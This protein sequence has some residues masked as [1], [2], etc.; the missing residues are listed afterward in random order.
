MPWL[1]ALYHVHYARWL[2]VHI[3]DMKTLHTSNPD[4]YQAFNNSG[5]FVVA[6][7]K[8]PFSSMG[9]DQRHEQHNKDLKGDGGILGL[10]EHEEKLR[11]WMVCGPE[12][13]RAVDEFELSS[14]LRR[15][16]T[17]E[18]RHHEQTPGFQKRFFN[19]VNTTTEEFNKLGN[20][21]SDSYGEDLVQISTRDVMDESVVKSVCSIEESGKRL[22]ETFLGERI[23]SRIK[24]IDDPIRKNK[25]ALFSTPY[26]R[27][28]PSMSETEKKGLKNDIRIFS[29]LYI[30]T[31]TRDGDL[32]TFFSHENSAVPP[33]LACNGKIRS[34]VKSDLLGCLKYPPTVELNINQP[35]LSE[36]ENESSIT[37][38]NRLDGKILE[39]SVLVNMLKPPKGSTFGEYARTL[40]LPKVAKELQSVSRIDIVFDCYKKNSLKETARQRRGTGIRRKV[41]EL[42]QTP[43]NW[44][45]FLRID[46]NKTELFSFL[47]EQMTSNP[48]LNKLVIAAFEDVVL[49][50]NQADVRNLSPC[51]H[52]EADTC[53]FLHALDMSNNGLQNVMIKLWILMWLYWQCLCMQS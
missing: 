20:P 10:T 5:C 14:V 13:A 37:A 53:V 9:L 1:F 51:N 38:P 47:S 28:H 25:F 43:S 48:E 41:E 36:T 24:D 26:Q 30:A 50:S 7:T 44:H 39:G 42:S 22:Y 29:Q 23:N 18:Y 19:H 16:E 27:K 15:E 52:E 2:S 35:G 34:G 3:H 40:F 33:A 17:T 8:N 11:R 32:D 45:S 6:R 12:V 21:F 46:K 49:T 31:Q 4:V